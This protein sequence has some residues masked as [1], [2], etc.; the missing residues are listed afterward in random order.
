MKKIIIILNIVFI[1]FIFN[2]CSDKKME[3]YYA[4]PDLRTDAKIEYLFTQ[5]QIKN[6][7]AVWTYWDF[8]TMVLEHLT[9]YAQT[10]GYVA[11]NSRFTQNVSYLGDRWGKYYFAL[12]HFREIEK[13]FRDVEPINQ[14]G[15]ELIL[16]LAQ[17]ITI[18]ETQKA[19]DL[20]GDIPY[21]KAGYAR[22]EAGQILFPEYDTQES[23]YLSMLSDLKNI[24]D[25]INNYESST[26]EQKTAFNNILKKADFMYAG[27]LAK[28]KKFVNSLRLRVAMRISNVNESTA[29][30]AIQEILNNPSTYPIIE[31]NDENAFIESKGQLLANS[32]INGS[33]V[34]GALDYQTGK[35]LAPGLMVS[36]M[37][38]AG[39]PR[40]AVYF[41][42][43]SEGN[44]VGLDP[45]MSMSEQEG[46]LTAE[47]VS[48][49]DTCT[50]WDN[51][52]LPNVLISAA[53]ISFIKAEAFQRWGGGN[54]QAAYENGIKLSVEY[55][56]SLQTGKGTKEA[57]P[58]ET[59][60]DDMIASSE[61]D[62]TTEPLKKIATQ[63][64]IDFGL[65][66]TYEAWAEQRRTGFPVFIDETA[67]TTGDFQKRPFRLN[68]P[69]TEISYNN[70][71]YQKVKD[72]DK[73]SIKVWWDVN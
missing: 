22:D 11:S 16:R 68:Y 21:S 29:K 26:Y 4:N 72:K 54:A 52:Y 24:A 8:G 49:F 38:N 20:W 44:I 28:W 62:Y 61:Y 48:R 70:E 1:S 47:L 13:L 50:L 60:I 55:W 63:K 66:N 45:A 18:H 30:S 27:D 53:E 46:L 35:N 37:K 9:V 14:Q 42:R 12:G 56:F 31:T 19:T 33:G 39:D 69:S 32:G 34:K 58:S 6:S 57:N 7:N 40:L 64:W 43:N 25:F 17:A 51:D 10:G 67:G 5:L 71:N 36:V 73:P 15:Y 2:S 41:G 65:I 23:I 3:E 59:A